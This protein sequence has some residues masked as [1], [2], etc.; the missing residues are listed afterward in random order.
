MFRGFFRLIVT[1]IRALVWCFP[2]EPFYEHIHHIHKSL[3]SPLIGK[4]II[5][6]SSKRL[7]QRELDNSTRMSLSVRFRASIQ[8]TEVIEFNY[9]THVIFKCELGIS[10]NL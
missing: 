8:R 7:S 9:Q 4:E 2:F 6:V 10:L 5:G 3:R 1:Q